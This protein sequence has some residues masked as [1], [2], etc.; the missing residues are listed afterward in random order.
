[1]KKYAALLL[2]TVS[3]LFTS[4]T[5]RHDTESKAMENLETRYEG[6]VKNPIIFHFQHAQ[7]TVLRAL[8]N[9]FP[10]EQLPEV[11]YGLRKVTHFNDSRSGDLWFGENDIRANFF[12]DL[13]NEGFEML[14]EMEQDS[15]QVSTFVMGDEQVTGAILVLETAESVQT[16]DFAGDI[17]MKELSKLIQ[18]GDFEQLDLLMDNPFKKVF[19]E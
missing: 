11:I 2:F 10:T 15:M 5:D 3:L 1:M 7:E 4:C 12:S 13:E 8:I 16:F 18:S 6:N 17:N 19:V 9:S 14:M